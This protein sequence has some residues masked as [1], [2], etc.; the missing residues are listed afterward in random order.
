MEFFLADLGS[1]ESLLD[2]LFSSSIIAVESFGI[3][4][5]SFGGSEPLRADE[6]AFGSELLRGEGS[7]FGTSGMIKS[8]SSGSE[9]LGFVTSGALGLVLR[10]LGMGTGFLGLVLGLWDG[11][12]NC[13]PVRGRGGIVDVA[14]G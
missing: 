4:C 10:G 3:D 13:I 12:L 8:Q 14:C 7:T 1:L 2:N 9:L 11:D 6:G 5:E